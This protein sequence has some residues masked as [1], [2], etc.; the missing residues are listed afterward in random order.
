MLPFSL[1]I[2]T[3]NESKNIE[4]CIQSVKNICSEIL[5]LDSFSTDNTRELAEAAGA[6]V[7]THVFDGHIQQKNRA[8]DLAKNNWVLSL[9]ADER[10]SEELVHSIEEVL[11]N[12]KADGYFMNRLNHYKGKPIRGCGWYPDAKLRLWK[13]DAGK[14]GG[15][16]PHDRFEL[17]A[18]NTGFLDGDILHFTYANKAAMLKQIEKFANISAEQNKNRS[19]FYLTGKM[20]FSSFFKFIK[21]YFFQSGIAYGKDG[22]DVCYQQAREVYLKYF[23]AIKL[24]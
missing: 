13:K 22:F 6:K 18:G 24:K 1:V 12:P 23:R 17:F 2:I 9:D 5:V 11:K 7:F 10:L 19:I 15:Q 4:D 16:N 21:T 8:K 3:F 20:V 14:W